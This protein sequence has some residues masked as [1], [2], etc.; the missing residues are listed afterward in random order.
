MRHMEPQI[1]MMERESLENTSSL[2][3]QDADTRTDS[4]VVA[5]VVVVVV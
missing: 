3:F 1:A 5:I 4:F 2:E